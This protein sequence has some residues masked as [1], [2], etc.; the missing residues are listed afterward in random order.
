MITFSIKSWQKEGKGRAG[1][2]KLKEQQQQQQLTDVWSQTFWELCVREGEK[3]IDSQTSVVLFLA[4]EDKD[5]FAR[6]SFISPFPVISLLVLAKL[7][8]KRFTLE[9]TGVQLLLKNRWVLFQAWPQAI[10]KAGL[11]GESCPPT[12]PCC[13]VRALQSLQGVAVR[14]QHPLYST[15]RGTCWH[16]W[17]PHASASASEAFFRRLCWNLLMR[18]IR[19]NY[20]DSSLST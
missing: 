1:K 9:I 6:N 18:E 8:V 7:K 15:L 10:T 3:N 17:Q 11:M 20:E 5:S 13:T 16:V 2:E 12:R 19:G 4:K 14:P